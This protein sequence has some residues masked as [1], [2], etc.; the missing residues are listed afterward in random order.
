MLTPHQE[1]ALDAI[2]CASE[3]RDGHV[4]LV[5][6][7]TGSGKTE[8][9]L[10]AIENE[11]EQGR[12]AIV[13]VPEISLT[14]QTVARFRGRFGDTVA[15]LHSRMSQGERFDQWD[16]IREGHTRVV[17]GARSA[18]FAPMEDVGIVII[19]GRSTNRATSRTRLP[20]YVTRDVAEWMVRSHGA[21]L[22]LGSATPSLEAL[23]RCCG[24]A[25]VEP[26]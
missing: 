7:V 21:V 1:E 3:K 20:R 8:V 18:L 13:L 5:D 14:P 2:T 4:V 23:H 17:V 15:V 6:G 10:R 25:F 11:L 9:Y 26:C 12:G 16:L 19:D 24:G 22:V